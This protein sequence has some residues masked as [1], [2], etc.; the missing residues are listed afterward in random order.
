[1]YPHPVSSSNIPSVASG[2]LR[3]ILSITPQYLKNKQPKQQ[4]LCRPTA[5]ASTVGQ[6]ECP[7]KPQDPI[8][9][10]PSTD[11]LLTNLLLSFSDSQATK[12]VE[13]AVARARISVRPCFKAQIRLQASG[14]QL[15][16]GS[17]PFP[18]CSLMENIKGR[19]V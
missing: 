11:H 3:Y 5:V 7:S 10:P 8:P 2:S 16:Q 1:M 19:V 14:S 9:S 15:C 18:P 4:T 17:Q 13:L 12:I 6:P